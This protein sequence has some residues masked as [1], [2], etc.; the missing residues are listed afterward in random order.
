MTRVHLLCA[1][2]A[3]FAFGASAQDLKTWGATALNGYNECSF[4]MQSAIMFGDDAHFA[5]TKRC[6][7][8]KRDAV[9]RQLQDV[10][11]TDP[12]TDRVRDFYSIWDSSMQA[13]IG[14]QYGSRA[15]SEL[16]YQ[17]T[18]Q[19]LNESWTRIEIDLPR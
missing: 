5:G 7:D 14:L 6:V 8:A 16:A 9:K 19:R 13:L 18:K 10:Q 15:N 12:L 11:R 3:M 2:A 1:A 17:A 4:L